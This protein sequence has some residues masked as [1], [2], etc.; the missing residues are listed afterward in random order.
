MSKD[1]GTEPALKELRLLKKRFDET[2]EK[3][4]MYQSYEETLGIQERVPVPQVDIFN[5]LFTKRETLWKNRDKFRTQESEWYAGQFLEQD[6]KGIADFVKDLTVQ[7][8]QMKIKL[9]KDEEDQVL[10]AFTEEVDR[11]NEHVPLIVALGN[12]A[13]RQKHWEKVYGKMGLKPPALD[14]GFTFQSLINEGVEKFKNEVEEISGFASG[15]EQ[16]END[17]AEI[18]TRW[19][20]ETD[21]TVVP[22]RDSNN[23][24][25]IK[26]VEDVIEQLENDSMKISTLLGSK[27]VK[28]IREDV[29]S[30]E[31]KLGYISYVIDEWLTFQ[32]SW[33][34]L[35]NIFSAEDI[36]KQLERET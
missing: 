18:K 21:F 13:M 1:F 2:L 34:Y 17:M 10:E 6:A 31:R 15:E 25:I 28:D 19:E 9:G 3:I 4:T 29:E 33:M 27:H 8:M 14:S 32:K 26:E 23:Y 20:E 11:V 30:W 12:K 5:K 16:I 35:E 22:Y 24:S 7:N 36:Q